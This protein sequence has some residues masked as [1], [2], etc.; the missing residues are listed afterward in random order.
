MVKDKKT[1][2]T[3]IYK[4]FTNDKEIYK[5]TDKYNFSICEDC[6]LDVLNGRNYIND[7]L[8]ISWIGSEVMFLPHEFNVYIKEYI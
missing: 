2:D 3:A 1:Y 6:L 8:K 4:C 7:I 5:N